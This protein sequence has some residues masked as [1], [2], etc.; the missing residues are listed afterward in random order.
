MLAQTAN[1]AK[2]APSQ[3]IR[4]GFS[5]TQVQR[6]SPFHYP[7]GPRSNIPFNPQTR[8]FAVRYWGFMATGFGIPFALAGKTNMAT[9]ERTALTEAYSLANIQK[10]I[11]RKG[12]GCEWRSHEHR[13]KEQIVH[14]TG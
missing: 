6:S 10:L 11:P 2:L 7:E 12:G 8:F 13:H 1:R 9:D 14:M 4:R 5:S 3:I